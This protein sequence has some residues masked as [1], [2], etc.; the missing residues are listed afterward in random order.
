MKTSQQWTDYFKANSQQ[1][2]IDWH[3]LPTITQ[4]EL[5]QILPSLKA[6]QLGE[7]SEAKNLIRASKKYAEQIN[8]PHYVPAVLLFI[9]EEQK[10][11]NNLG[12][13][14][15]AIGEERIQKDWGDTLFRKVRGWNTNMEWWTLAVITVECTAQIFYQCLKDATHCTLLKQICTDI[16][17]DE[18]PHIQFQKE[19]LEII[20]TAKAS[21][22]QRLTLY[23]YQ[24]FFWATS[25][26]VWYGHSKLFKAGN[27]GFRKYCTKMNC[28]YYKTIGR[29]KESLYG[30]NHK[31]KMAELA[32]G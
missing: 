13:Y 27:V 16:L 8:D 5:K 3:L 10:H 21:W 30:S 17:I 9:K 18:A 19:R 20:F 32:T 4:N 2:R 22:Q 14:L 28:K 23:F 6:W 31:G 15:D 26:L 11:G 25:L 29:L 7:T 24:L 12:K 1:H